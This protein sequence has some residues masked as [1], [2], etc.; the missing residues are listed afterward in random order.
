MET[1]HP[2]ASLYIY[3]GFTAIIY[4]HMEVDVVNLIKMYF[5]N[6]LCLLS[7]VVNVWFMVCP[8]NWDTIFYVAS[9][10]ATI[11]HGFTY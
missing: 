6:I 2:L 4:P 8:L 3:L 7:H 9:D 11:E 5:A 1:P 10:K